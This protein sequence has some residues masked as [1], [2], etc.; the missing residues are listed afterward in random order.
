MIDSDGPRIETP[1]EC[2]RLS[3]RRCGAHSPLAYSILDSQRGNTVRLYR[4]VTCE[5][6]M[7]DDDVKPI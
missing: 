1:M 2:W 7:W 3:C 4:C 5:E 6:Y